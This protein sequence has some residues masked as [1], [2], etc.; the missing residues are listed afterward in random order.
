MQSK[1]SILKPI[2]PLATALDHPRPVYSTAHLKRATEANQTVVV[3]NSQG[4]CVCEIFAVF[5]VSSA[6]KIITARTV[7]N[8]IGSGGVPTPYRQA[9]LSYTGWTVLKFFRIR[10]LPRSKPFVSNV[11][12]K[13]ATVSYAFSS[14]GGWL[15]RANVQWARQCLHGALWIVVVRGYTINLVL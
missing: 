3:R 2:L 12:V 5:G 14:S 1:V 10:P 13:A 9:V 11:R 8:T 7:H 6:V 15:G 4:V